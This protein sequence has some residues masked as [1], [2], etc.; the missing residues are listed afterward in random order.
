MEGE[1]SCTRARGNKEASAA[2]G[3]KR[4]KRELAFMCS[5]RHS[6]LFQSSWLSALLERREATG[7]AIALA[8]GP[9]FQSA[10]YCR[11]QAWY[12]VRGRKLERRGLPGQQKDGQEVMLGITGCVQRS[13][14][15]KSR[16][17]RAALGFVTALQ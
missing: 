9:G 17:R 15:A 12:D 14:G 6:V 13:K 2:G 3:P 16:D 7:S 1:G 11:F 10:L 8:A 5:M 4:E